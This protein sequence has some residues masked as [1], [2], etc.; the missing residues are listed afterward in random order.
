VRCVI[1]MVQHGLRTSHRPFYDNPPYSL[2][3]LYRGYLHLCCVQG[4]LA[5]NASWESF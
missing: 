4:K 2:P 1:L 5:Q 3:R